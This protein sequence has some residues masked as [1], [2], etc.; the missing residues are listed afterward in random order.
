MRLV[1]PLKIGGVALGSSIA[2][3]FNFFML[4]HLLIK[5]I[6]KINLKDVGIQ[7]LKILIISLIISSLAR[8]FWYRY[9][10]NRYLKALVLIFGY[11]IF[12]TSAGLALKLPQVNFAKKWILKKR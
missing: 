5:K 3:I 9:D 11:L 8:F 2:A 10:F 6:G 7:F 4:Y 12:Y 1:Y